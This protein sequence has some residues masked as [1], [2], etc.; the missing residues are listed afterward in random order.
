MKAIR[1]WWGQR[2]IAA[3]ETF[4]DPAR[5][6]RGRGYAGSDRIKTWKLEP[7]SLSAKIRGNV[8]PYFGVHKEPLYDTRIAL[9]TIP[10]EDWAL[11]IRYLGSRAGL[12]ARLLLNEMPDTVE[13]PFKALDLRLL[14]HGGRDFSTRCSCPDYANPCKHV[15]GLCYFLA[16][17]LD[18]DPFLLFELR[19]LAREELF[20]QLRE[21]PLGKALVE[22]L[23]A[24]EAAPF[25]PAV[26]YFT[27]P[28]AA[29][30]PARPDPLAF[31]QGRKRLPDTLETA[32]A[33][34]PALAVR[35]GGDFPE[36]WNEE[37]PF[38]ATLESV[39]EAVRKRVKE[40]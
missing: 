9:K 13:K 29:E 19:G 28:I 31:W 20:R 38:P 35:K 1:T 15:A 10:P 12:V 39:Y 21:T 14:P 37:Q 4:T 2:F 8:N 6:A 5:L 26:S 25:E 23:E 11:V 22:T 16:A 40:W 32:A 24:E 18:R 27:R 17:Q 36:F 34:V 3:L 33:A 30:R 7:G